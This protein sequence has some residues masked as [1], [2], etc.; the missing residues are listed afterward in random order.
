MKWILISWVCSAIAM[1][2][3]DPTESTLKY[4]T[5]Q[6]CIAAGY[7]QGIQMNNKLPGEFINRNRIYMAFSC[8][9][10]HET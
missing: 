2:C 8:K 4:N 3:K 1:G 5:F 7:L 10:Y 6:E 9:A